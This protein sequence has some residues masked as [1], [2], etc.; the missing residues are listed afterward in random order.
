MYSIGAYLRAF[1]VAPLA[2]VP[3]VVACVFV[4][5]LFTPGGFSA[6]P[7]RLAAGVFVLF[8]LPVAY[9]ATFLFA[10]PFVVSANRARAPITAGSALAVGLVIGLAASALWLYIL[11]PGNS[12]PFLLLFIGAGSG[13][14]TAYAFERLL[15]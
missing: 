1:L 11:S 2:A 5:G 15:R 6:A 14:A 12:G 3:V 10:T 8:T 9:L 4:S 13:L 7:F